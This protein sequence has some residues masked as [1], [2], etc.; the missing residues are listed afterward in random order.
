MQMVS[1]DMEREVAELDDACAHLVL[2]VVPAIMRDIAAGV[3]QELEDGRWLTMGQ[4]RVLYLI[5]DGV[6]FVSELARFQ[7][8]SQPTISRQVDGLVTKGL[9]A[10]HTDPTDRRVIHLELTEQ[11][12]TL[13]ETIRTRLYHRVAETLTALSPTEKEQVAEGLRLL[14]VRFD[15]SARL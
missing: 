2:E 7:N 10:R 11:G 1:M 5:H 12:R 15:H 6:A 4:F 13:L 3:H 9:V 8:V 14:H